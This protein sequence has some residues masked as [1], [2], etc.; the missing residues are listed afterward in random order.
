MLSGQKIQQKVL[1][2]IILIV[3]IIR[4][5]GLVSASFDIAYIALPHFPSPHLPSGIFS[6]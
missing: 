3:P 5:G 4:K 6:G 2:P 1:M